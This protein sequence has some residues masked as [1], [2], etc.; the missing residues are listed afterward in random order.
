M[1]EFEKLLRMAREAAGVTAEVVKLLESVDLTPKHNATP[2]TL[3]GD[4]NIESWHVIKKSIRVRLIETLATYGALTRAQVF[5]Y[6]GLSMTS[7]PMSKLYAELRKEEVIDDTTEGQVVLVDPALETAHRQPRQNSWDL[8]S[9]FAKRVGGNGKKLLEAHYKGRRKVE[10]R[11]HLCGVAGVSLTSGP[12]SA[13][14]ARLSKLDV[15][16]SH[17]GTITFSDWYLKAIEPTVRSFD[18]QTGETRHHNAKSGM[19]Q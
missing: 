6:S 14:F 5:F 12:T 8:F 11:D 9:A 10:G 4:S 15:L 13:A 19:P 17:R 2:L 7:G 18:L 3:P 1:S 16:T